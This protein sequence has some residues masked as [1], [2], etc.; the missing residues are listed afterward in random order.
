M[1]RSNPF[2]NFEHASHVTMSVNKLLQ[3]V[4]APEVRVRRRSLTCRNDG[5]TE[6]MASHLHNYTHGITSDPL[7]QF[8][9]VFSALIHDVDHW[10]V[11][12]AQLVKEGVPIAEKYH[13]K[14]VAEQN[15]VDL[16]FNLL[17][18]EDDYPDLRECIFPTKYEYERF[19]QV[20]VNN[21]MATDIFDPE[22]QELSKK[23]WEKAF[24]ERT[25][26]D[27][28]Y[29]NRKATVVIEHIM[30]ASDVSHSMQHWHVYQKWNR[31]L[32][33]E[34][35]TAYRAGRMAVDP[36]TFWVEG[37][38]KFFDNHIIPLA[39]KLKECGVFGASSDECLNYAMNNRREWM[40]KGQTIVDELVSNYLKRDEEEKLKK[41]Q[42]EAE[43]AG[44]NGKKRRQ[45]RFARRR[46][47]FTSG[48]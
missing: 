24:S 33:D 26:S 28:D 35:Y 8:A 2:H 25:E 41:E 20:V 48:G 42:A 44:P 13:N 16:S 45:Q 29:D 23:R 40:S 3:R 12:N 1:Y 30:Q 10:G 31:R 14:T 38:L 21:V 7:T 15:S 18:N 46:S 43:S 39:T 22:L 19:R 34:L 6:Q 36:T 11:S 9:V 17:M 27:T 47:L 4:V 32:F 5:K 37:E